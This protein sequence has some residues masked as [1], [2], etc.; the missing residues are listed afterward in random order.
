MSV[1]MCCFGLLLNPS[2]VAVEFQFLNWSDLLTFAVLFNFCSMWHVEIVISLRIK[3][4]RSRIFLQGTLLFCCSRNCDFALSEILLSLASQCVAMT[5]HMLNIWNDSLLST[6]CIPSLVS[7]IVGYC[8]S[9]TANVRKCNNKF[10][11]AITSYHWKGWNG[12]FA[13]ASLSF[14]EN[15]EFILKV[16]NADLW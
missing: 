16:R 4:G 8:I 15:V 14:Q 2:I 5:Y 9:T 12:L 13:T 7:Y 1:F 11:L 3:F 10:T 6:T